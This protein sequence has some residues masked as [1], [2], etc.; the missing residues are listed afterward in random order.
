MAP[1]SLAVRTLHV[2]TMAVLVGGTLAVWYG[3]RTEAVT[4]L[5]LARRY[6]W[7][8]WAALGVLVVTG[9]GNLGAVGAPGPA[10]AWGRTFLVK[11]VLVLAVVVGSAV[12]TLAVVHVTDDP[13]AGAVQSPVVGRLYGA[14]TV[15]LVA[16]VVLAEVL[17]HG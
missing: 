4:D 14:T 10:T 12:R 1:L 11:L 13:S 15:A 17:A 6:E 8:F 3:Y 5:S 16:V 7:G 2:L 9:V